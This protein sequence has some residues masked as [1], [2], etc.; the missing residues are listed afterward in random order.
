MTFENQ[1]AL[2]PNL[3]ER[4]KGIVL[5]PKLEWP[6]IAYEAATVKGLFTRYAMVLAAIGPVC[7]LVGS[8]LFGA[9]NLL[10]LLIG[11]IVGYGLSLVAVYLMG[12]IIDTLA[13]S[14]GSE[15]NMVQSMKLAVY[16]MTPYWLAGVFNLI[17]FLAFIGFF[18]MIYG[19]YVLYLGLQPLKKTPADK[20][21]LYTIVAV[22]V[23]GVLNLVV[24]TLAGLVALPFVAIGAIFS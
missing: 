9:D 23:A 8:A 15:Q 19:F 22:L 4:V 6:V 3:V 12:I 17:P 2:D 10:G 7:G 24:I 20:A 1:Q 21:V 14:F 5:K 18:A 13:V 16:S 11:A